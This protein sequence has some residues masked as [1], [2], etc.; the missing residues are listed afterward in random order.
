[1][2][3]T[4]LCRTACRLRWRAWSIITGGPVDAHHVGAAA[5]RGG[6]GHAWATADLQHAI[7]R[8]EAE[9]AY[10][11]GLRSVGASGP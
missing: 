1:M 11:P 7:A 9:Q 3:S 2:R 5:G 6:D 4:C 8:P 10:G